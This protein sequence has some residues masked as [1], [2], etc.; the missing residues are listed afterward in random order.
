[1]PKN[2]YQRDGTWWARFKVRGVEYRRS[3]RTTVRGEAERRLGALRKQVEG[4]VR[5]GIVEPRSFADAVDSWTK[6][7]VGDLN[8][9][10]VKR[11][12]TSFKQVWPFLADKQ[13]HRIDVQTLRDMVKARRIG[14][15]S[16]ATIKR[17]LTAISGVLK[18]A[19]DEDWM[20]EVN[21]TLAIRA[22]G[23]MKEKRDPIEL[24]DAADIKAV[25][26]RSAKR[27]ADAIDFARETGMRL[28]EIFNLKHRDVGHSA[29][30]IPRAKHNSLRVIPLSDRAREIIERQPRHI[31]ESWVF[32]HTDGQRWSSPSSSFRENQKR[33]Q[34]AAQ[35]AGQEYRHF[36]FHDL[37][38]LFA[39]EY[40]RAKRGS[41][42]DLQRVMGHT[43]ITTTEI[44]LKYL[45]P[46]QVRAAM[47]G[48]TNGGTDAAVYA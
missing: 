10:T 24:P 30:T 16:T 4:E 44:Y 14:G 5:F 23:K 47:F 43:S 40:L 26:A 22:K 36:R 7:C 21:P 13:V 37:R 42:Y 48:G 18:H 15:A 9:K 12:M 29:I 17:D 34:K 32:W 27:F 11:Y 45:T 31:K 2:L 20:E 38:H 1:M 39:V 3:L 28:S 33:A 19:A 6:H 25:K 41:I 46:D 8:P 35:K